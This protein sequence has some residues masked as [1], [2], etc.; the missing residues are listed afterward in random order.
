MFDRSAP[1]RSQRIGVLASVVGLHV[2]LLVVFLVASDAAPP[3]VVKPGVMSLIALNAEVPAQRPPPPPVLPSKLVDEIRK[4]TAEAQAME[5]D[6]TALAAPSGQCATLDV[7]SKAI[8][9]DP[10]AVMAVIQ[11]PPETR[12]IAEAVVMWNAGWSNAAST[13]QSPL[14]PARTV[15][16]QTLGLVENGC[17][18]EPIVGPR[19]VQIA[20]PDG[21]RTMFLVFG[22]G[23]WTWRQLVEDPAAVQ[24][25]AASE[26]GARPWYE[27]D[28]F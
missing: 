24:E 28:W 5:P 22:S 14:S 8:V 12:S 1:P 15:V 4:L 16:E 25:A 19:L 18:D 13:P 11:S 9:A 27:I 20:V 10:S 7:V 23:H 21:Q 26:A 2:G 3:Q 6:S 17:L